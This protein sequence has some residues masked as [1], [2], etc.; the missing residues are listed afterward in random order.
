LQLLDF[1]GEGLF[2]L[3]DG[4]SR[5]QV[6]REDEKPRIDV[7]RDVGVDARKEP[8][9]LDEPFVEPCRIAARQDVGG[10]V[11]QIEIPRKAVAHGVGDRHRRGRYVALDF[12][13]TFGRL[14]GFGGQRA[15]CGGRVSDRGEVAFSQFED[16][17]FVDVGR[18]R[19]N[20][21][22]G[23]VPAAVEGAH[24]VDRRAGHMVGRKPDRSP[25]VRVEGIGQRTQQHSLIAVRLI[26]I[27][28]LVLLDDDPFFGFERFGRDVES[29]HAVGFQPE[30]R[31]DIVL[32]QGNIEVRIIVIGE[33]VV[34]A[35]GHLHRQ[36]EIG[37][38]ARAAEHE[39]FEQVREARAGGIFVARPDLVEDVYGREFRLAV[40]VDG[41]RQPVGKGMSFVR[42]HRV[43]FE[44]EIVQVACRI[45]CVF[46]PERRL[47]GRNSPSA[48]IEDF[49]G[50]NNRAECEKNN[51][52]T[53]KKLTQKMLGTLG[54]ILYLCI[55]LARMYVCKMLKINNFQVY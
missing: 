24:L 45:R 38:V 5:Q 27:T 43:G 25:A 30:G 49:G 28:L 54:G 4:A 52:P 48:K 16:P 15:G 26:E 6:P 12:E 29:G 1:A 9:A 51:I 53:V 40:A 20:G 3:L 11:A 47:S 23:V 32:R 50:E 34:V 7:A 42:Y 8:V 14:F 33:G 36:V 19:Q 10:H 2:G 22:R 35:A 21:V 46:L 41:H 37:H 18:D 44:A 39:V 31:L 17:L 13:P 55:S